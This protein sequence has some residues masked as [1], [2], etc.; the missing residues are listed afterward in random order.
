MS[1]SSQT[2]TFVCKLTIICGEPSEENPHPPTCS[3]LPKLIRDVDSLPYGITF[4]V[5]NIR[6]VKDLGCWVVIDG[7]HYYHFKDD[8]NRMDFRFFLAENKNRNIYKHIKDFFNV[9]PTRMGISFHGECERPDGEK[10]VM[11]Q[12]SFNDLL[13]DAQILSV[14]KNFDTYKIL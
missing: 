7:N 2:S 8:Q 12:L 5:D 14:L 1:S 6:E 3:E 10:Q 4:G 11:M 13:T 9:A